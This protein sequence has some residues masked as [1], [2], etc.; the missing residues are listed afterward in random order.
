MKVNHGLFLFCFPDPCS[1]RLHYTFLLLTISYHTT[2]HDHIHSWIQWAVLN[3]N[4]LD[5][6]ML[7]LLLNLGEQHQALLNRVIEGFTIVVGSHRAVPCVVTLLSTVIADDRPSTSSSA[8]VSSTTSSTS[9]IILRRSGGVSMLLAFHCLNILC[10]F[11][12]QIQCSTVAI[13][14]AY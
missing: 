12:H 6:L 7:F 13:I 8:F 4:E 14:M 10:S 1:N 3:S 11:N 5:I 9:R 2:A